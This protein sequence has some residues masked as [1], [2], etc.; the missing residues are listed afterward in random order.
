MNQR[1]FSRAERM[2]RKFGT[3]D[4]FEL[5]DGMK[6]NVLFSQNYSEK[7]L[8]GYCTVLNRI[9]YC[10]INAKLN[11][12]EQKI[13]GSHECGH[14]LLHSEDLRI[15]TL[16]DFD[17]Y[18]AKGRL[19]REANLFAA[20]FAISDEEVADRIMSAGSDFFSVAGDLHVPAPFFAFKLYSMVERGFALRLPMEPD[21]GFMKAGKAKK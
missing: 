20:D 6:V 2:V 16:S 1:I 12:D 21:S 13:V 19:E 5:M 9:K 3:R 15:G 14:L 17:I 7:G 4:P 11:P 18:N 8:K 10:V